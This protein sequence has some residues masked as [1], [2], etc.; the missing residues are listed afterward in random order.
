MT[1]VRLDGASWNLIVFHHAILG[2]MDLRHTGNQHEVGYRMGQQ[3][4]RDVR[5]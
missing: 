4:I 1:M 2:R 3:G 5:P